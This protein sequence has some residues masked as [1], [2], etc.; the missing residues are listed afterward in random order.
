MPTNNQTN[1]SQLVR[2]QLTI[3]SWLL[4]GAVIQGI[5]HVLLPYR[6]I[7]IVLPVF[8]FMAYKMFNTLLMLIGLVPNPRMT[9]TLPYRTTVV[10][11]DSN[12]N[13]DK[14]GSEPVCAILLGVVS[15]HPLGA[16]GP[17]FKD[18]GGKFEAMLTELSNDASTHGFLGSSSWINAHE[19]TTS[20]EYASILYFD[21]EESLY[22]YAH[23]PLHSEVMQWWRKEGENLKH[24]GIM[25]E[26]FAC[27]KNGWEGVY[28]NYHP[29]G[30][31]ITCSGAY[32]R[33]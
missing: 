33:C 13:Q 11:P 9:K 1:N 3:T 16:F 14:P 10:Y 19:R 2:D 7:L 21:N 6:N 17:G 30:K 27:P 26:V 12:G 8:L 29:T 23:G 28:L 15:H 20:N 18:V 4:L 32:V 24:V 22:K 31:Y 5:A 25:H